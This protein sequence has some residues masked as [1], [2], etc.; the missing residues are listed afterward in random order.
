M[1]LNFEQIRLRDGRTAGFSG[2][3]EDVHA[4][5]NEDVR[6]NSESSNVQESDSQ[7]GRTAQRAAIGAAVGAIIGAIANGGKGAAIGAAI[8]AGAGVGSVYAQG[9]D[10]L[11]L[12]NGTELVI[13][14]GRTR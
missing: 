1:T 14:A 9:R 10:D 7:G 11:Q 4:A 13:R 2:I 6:I 5:G 3:V 12:R 8:G